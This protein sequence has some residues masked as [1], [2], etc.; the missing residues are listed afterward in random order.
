MSVAKF[1]HNWLEQLPECMTPVSN[2]D[3][4]MFADLI[5]RSLYYHCLED[6]YIQ[7]ELCELSEADNNFKKFFDQAFVAESRRKSL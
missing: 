4:K 7:K 3:L 2:D 6:Q 1:T 5:K